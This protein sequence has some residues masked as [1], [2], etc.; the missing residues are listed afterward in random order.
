MNVKFKRPQNGCAR[1][2]WW[3]QKKKTGNG[4]CHAQGEQRWFQFPPCEEYELRPDVPD[5]IDVEE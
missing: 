1:C 4:F 2:V 3:S 5:E